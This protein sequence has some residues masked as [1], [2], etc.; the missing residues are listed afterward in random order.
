[1][2]GREE[3]SDPCQDERQR[4]G[5]FVAVERPLAVTSPKSTTPNA[6]MSARLPRSCRL[7]GRHVSRCRIFR[8][9]IA[10]VV[11]VPNLATHTA[12]RPTCL[13]RKVHRLGRPNRGPSRSRRPHLDIGR[14]QIAVDDAL[15]VS[16][17]ERVGD[18]PRD[19]QLR[20]AASRRARCAATIR[21]LRPAHH[22]RDCRGSSRP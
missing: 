14:F 3:K 15:P 4:I 5:H 16:G 20:R 11:I 17:F 18:L 7:L 12:C 21:R 19:C 8:G 6:Q 9:V 2:A 1:M 22:Q 10:G 13:T